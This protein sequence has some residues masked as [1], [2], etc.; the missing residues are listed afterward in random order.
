ML[1][2]RTQDVREHH[3]RSDLV[4]I[5]DVRMRVF[6]V[7]SEELFV[8]NEGKQTVLKLKVVRGSQRLNGSTKESVAKDVLNAEKDGVNALQK[9]E[10]DV[11][12]EPE[13]MLDDD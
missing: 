11:N 13:D 4:E 8:L 9:D 3:R 12:E 10:A 5:T 1:Y 7:M 2:R 6:F